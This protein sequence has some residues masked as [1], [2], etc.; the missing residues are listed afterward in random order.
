MRFG[1]ADGLADDR[2]ADD[3]ADRA[4]LDQVDRLLLGDGERRG[5]AVRLHHVRARVDAA[6]AELALASAP[7]SE[8]PSAA[9]RR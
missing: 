1:D 2:R 4:G 8:L 6:G 3:A 5:A 7:G 9:R